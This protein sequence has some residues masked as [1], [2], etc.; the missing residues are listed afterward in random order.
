MARYNTVS[1]VA[2]TT[3]ATTFQSPGTGLFT[4][5]TGTAPYT[6]TLPNPALF[7]GATQTFRNATN[8][9]VTLSTPNGIFVGPTA[10]G[11]NAQALPLGSAITIVSDGTNYTVVSN[12]GAAIVG[13]TINANGIASLTATTASTTTGTGALVVSGG[14][15]VAGS[16]FV[17]GTV[18]TNA[19]VNLNVL[20]G[21]TGILTLDS[22]STGAVNLGTNANAKTV[23]IGNGTG[24][25]AITIN[26]GTGTINI[27]TNAIARTVAVGN[28]TGASILN[29][30]AGTGGVSLLTGTTGGVSIDSGTTGAINVGTNANAKTITIGN[31]T[32]ATSVVLNAGTGAI[33][34]GTNGIARTIT[35]G[36]GTGASSVVIEAGTGAINIG[37]NG[38]ARTITIGNAT[39]ASS[40][41]LNAGT[42][43]VTVPSAVASSSTT[44]GA[45]R[46]SGGVGIAGNLFVGGTGNFTGLLN[47]NGGTSGIL[48]YVIQSVSTTLA[49]VDRHYLLTNTSAITLT[50]P[51]SPPNGR[52]IIISDGNNAANNVVTVSRNGRNIAGVAENLIINVRGSRIELVYFDNDWKVFA[53]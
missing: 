15:G 8:G 5:L 37:T 49:D 17:G 1:P 44:T 12:I 9:V 2:T 29:L 16:L 34:I 46:V 27:G 6:V 36:N 53:S 33:N 30:R 51:A 48:N 10:S 35:V 25:T 24:A 4:S 45:L 21:T 40:L 22:G 28:D 52:A 19:A 31:G 32:G 3:G 26:A 14:V 42:A 13:T 41:V 7:T 18:S 47:A 39:G 38:I 20:T 43:N 50:L 23:T 11:T